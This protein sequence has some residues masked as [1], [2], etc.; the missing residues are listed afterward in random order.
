MLTHLCY[1]NPREASTVHGRCINRNTAGAI[2][3]S[4]VSYG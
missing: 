2:G 4:A 1:Y 3:A